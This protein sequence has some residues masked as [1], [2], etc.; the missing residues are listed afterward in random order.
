MITKTRKQENKKARSFVIARSWRPACRHLPAGRQGPG[1]VISRD[2]FGCPRNDA[3]SGFTLPELLV[4][5]GLFLIVVSIV[6]G[7]FVQSLRTQR[8]SVELIAVNDN[9]SLILEQIA[10]E[11]R[12]GI[13]FF[14]PDISELRFTNAK[15]QAVVYRLNMERGTIEKSI[16]GG[17]NYESMT[18]SNVNV[19]RFDFVVAGTAFLDKLQPRVTISLSVAGRSKLLED[20]NT[21]L[22]TT[23]SPRL[24]DS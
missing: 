23:I 11:I 18:A 24:L 2:C 19:K 10:R 21:N 8:A 22:Q 16:D 1:A 3:R 17:L 5:M 14:S 12:T 9:V 15:N 7:A 4:S 13:G 6:A 20:V